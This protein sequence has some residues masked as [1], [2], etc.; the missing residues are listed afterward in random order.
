MSGVPSIVY[1]HLEARPESAYKQ[2]FIKG[3]RIRARAVY[4]LYS[5]TEDP[6]TPEFIAEQYH[7]PVEAVK[8]AIAYCRSNPPEIARDYRGEESL[9]DAMGVNDPEYGKTGKTRVLS[10]E[11]LTRILGA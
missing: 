10:G 1:Q 2:F 11:E 8:E 6:W 4:G 9:M 3:T 7:L 5:S